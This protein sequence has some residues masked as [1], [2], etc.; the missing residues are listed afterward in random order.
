MNQCFPGGLA[1]RI[2]EKEACLKKQGSF[3]RLKE[4]LMEKE[5]LTLRSIYRFLTVNDFPDYSEGIIGRERKK[6]LTLTKFWE[7]MLCHTFKEGKYGKMLFRTMGGRNRYLSDICNRSERLGCYKEYTEELI[8]QLNR[9]SLSEQIRLFSAFLMETGFSFEAFESKLGKLIL[10]FQKED[11]CFSPEIADFFLKI[12]K[13]IILVRGKSIHAKAF[14][15]GYVLSQLTLHALFGTAMNSESAKG[16]RENPEFSV[17]QLWNQYFSEVKEERPVQRLTNQNNELCGT[18][19]PTHR[20]FGREEEMFEMRGMLERGGCYLFTGIG[21]IGKTELMRQF[22]AFCEKTQTVDYVATVS[23]TGDLQKSITDAFLN[24][25]E[26]GME[27]NLNRA[28]AMIRKHKHERVLLMIDNL[29]E[30]TTEVLEELKSLP[31][32]IFVTS[33]LPEL[34]GFQTI[35]VQAPSQRIC[36]MIFCDNYGKALFGKE[37]DVFLEFLKTPSLCHTLTMRVLG[38]TAA[39]RNW[40]VTELLQKI[41]QNKSKLLLEYQASSW[42]LADIYRQIYQMTGLNEAEKRLL[43][44]MA[45]LPYFIYTEELLEKLFLGEKTG[46]GEGDFQTLASLGWLEQKNGDFSMH[47]YIAECV[48]NYSAPENEMQEVLE[49][50]CLEITRC[51]QIAPEERLKNRQDCSNYWL[52]LGNSILATYRSELPESYLNY[53]FS[54]VKK[55]LHSGFLVV[56]IFYHNLT[57]LSDKYFKKYPMEFATIMLWMNQREDTELDFIVEQYRD[58]ETAFEITYADFLCVYASNLLYKNREEEAKALLEEAVVRG[59]ASEELLMAYHYMGMMYAASCN[60]QKTLEYLLCGREAAKENQNNE[61]LR[62]FDIH[63]INYL[64]AMRRLTEVEEYIEEIEQLPVKSD[65]MM[66]NSYLQFKAQYYV[67]VEKYE[68]ALQCIQEALRLTE[69]LF[70]EDSNEY[71]ACLDTY[72]LVLEK[73]KKYKEAE[74]YYQRLIDGL[75]AFAEDE[76]YLFY[77]HKILN[78]FGVMYLGMEDAEHAYEILARGYEMAKKIGGIALGEAANNLSRALRLKENY[79]EEKKYLKEALPLLEAVY[80]TE[81]KKVQDARERLNEQHS[82]E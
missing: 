63:I 18:A 28:F 6:G 80:G 34:P 81:H 48:R 57:E 20:F 76:F 79:R 30:Y 40:S 22:L 52:M 71:F 25:Q 12:Q 13:D 2:G 59:I 35:T 3:S 44:R 60:F 10:L 75:S 17:K 58:K 53:L 56:S 4:R 55:M 43:R 29:S 19:L 16:F 65:D 23:C 1:K 38:K 36:E 82:K 42:Q 50:I 70:R 7:S 9:Q 14:Y 78:N 15:C 8:L 21:G 47:P 54:F 67:F 11:D 39:L 46:T 33:R 69:L 51:E 66:K 5:K 27:G 72:C 62:L 74:L 77:Y 68:K 32:T 61:M 73:T 26:Y 31:A 24:Y 37:R 45:R 41:S 64:T 49:Q